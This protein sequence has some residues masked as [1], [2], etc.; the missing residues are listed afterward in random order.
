[1][2]GSVAGAEERPW[3][4][5]YRFEVY[6]VVQM[7][8]GAETSFVYGEFE[9]EADATPV[10][11][12]GLGLNLNDHL[13]INTEFLLGRMSTEGNFP[14]ASGAHM[15]LG[16][17]VGLWSLN[18]DYN[19]FKSRLTPLVT[20]GLGFI[21]FDNGD[22]NVNETD[23]SYNVGVGGRWDMSDHIA[24]RVIYRSTWTTLQRADDSL[25]F[26]GVLANLSFMFK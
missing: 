18:L 17:T 23:F 4:R 14:L 2:A 24:L 26:D 11:G 7:L 6:P 19:L 8:S 20:G 10:F 25:R 5:A 9:L 13:N 22:E 16:L 12:A 1:M 3:S 21:M 15:D